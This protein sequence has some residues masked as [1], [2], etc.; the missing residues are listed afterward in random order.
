MCIVYKVSPP[1]VTETDPLVWWKGEKGHF[2]T[3]A[4][5]K[6]AQKYLSVWY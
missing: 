4:I 6:Q 5:A 1:V 3:L 2:P